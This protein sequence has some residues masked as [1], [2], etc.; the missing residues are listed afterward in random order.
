MPNTNQ[1]AA[2]KGAITFLLHV[3]HLGRALPEQQRSASQ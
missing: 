3:E 2:G 1:A